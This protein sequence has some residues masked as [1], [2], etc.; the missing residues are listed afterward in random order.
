[1][2][3][4]TSSHTAQT[5]NLYIIMYIKI[6]NLLDACPDEH[7]VHATYS[8]LIDDQ[9]PVNN[10]PAQKKIYIVIRYSKLQT[11]G[12]NTTKYKYATK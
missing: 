8:E 9:E 2:F 6:T 12:D 10:N 3:D 5:I 1:M 11:K 4:V 7:D